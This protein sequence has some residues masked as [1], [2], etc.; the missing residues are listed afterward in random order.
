M[1]SRQE[2]AL[3]CDNQL[4]IKITEAE[5]HAEMICFMK[6]KGFA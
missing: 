5:R 1:A 2:F 6:T 4:F 3:I